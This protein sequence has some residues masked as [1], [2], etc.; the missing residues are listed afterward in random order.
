MFILTRR[1]ACKQS[2]WY[3]SK[4]F[5]LWTDWKSQGRSQS[6]RIKRIQSSKRMKEVLASQGAGARASK[7]AVET[8]R[9]QPLA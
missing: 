8:V 7:E 6:Q 4:T 1:E 3:E 5:A 9:F 2:K